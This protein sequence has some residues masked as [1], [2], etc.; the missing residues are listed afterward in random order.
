MHATEADT[1]ERTGRGPDPAVCGGRFGGESARRILARAAALQQRLDNEL[2]GSYT[3]EELEGM[4]AEAG[5]SPEALRAAI[6]GYGSDSAPD[7]R[8]GR[9]H[10]APRSLLPGNRSRAVKGAVL[11]TAGLG[12]VGLL[13]AFPVV[14]E[15][16]LWAV[17]SFLIVIAVLVALGASPF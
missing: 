13:A 14:A 3:L 16:V 7:A 15:I 8:P 5:I 6:E 1:P 10:P 11:T 2:A 12:F 17:L 9:R 4:A